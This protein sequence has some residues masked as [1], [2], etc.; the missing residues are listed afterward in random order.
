VPEL[1]EWYQHLILYYFTC[2][3]FPQCKNQRLS[4]LQFVKSIQSSLQYDLEKDSASVKK[5]VIS[6]NLHLILNNK[7][8]LRS[9]Y[10]LISLLNKQFTYPL[11]VKIVENQQASWHFVWR[12]LYGA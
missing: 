4:D 5:V 10:I 7:V 3:Q 11:L 6:G 2:Y 1:Y 9:K 12:G 8:E